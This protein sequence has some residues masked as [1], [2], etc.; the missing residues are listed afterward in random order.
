MHIHA[1]QVL[2]L[3]HFYKSLLKLSLKQKKKVEEKLLE[4]KPSS[5]KFRCDFG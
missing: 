5:I 4:P 2:L 1:I 3:Q